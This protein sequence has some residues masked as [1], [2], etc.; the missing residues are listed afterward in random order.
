[1][2]QRLC[3]GNA[4]SHL[5]PCLCSFLDSEV[6]ALSRS[7]HSAVLQ[8]DGSILKKGNDCLHKRFL[9]RKTNQTTKKKNRIR[10]IVSLNGS[11]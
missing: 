10:V 3:T 2:G 1:M 8:V 7:P 11:S 9:I 5:L 6:I 4:D